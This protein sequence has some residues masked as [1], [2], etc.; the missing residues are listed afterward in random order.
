MLHALIK[1]EYIPVVAGGTS[2]HVFD[3][4]IYDQLTKTVEAVP[5]S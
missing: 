2:E 1:R 5:I 3:P 4:S